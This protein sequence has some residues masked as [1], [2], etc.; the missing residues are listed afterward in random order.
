MN[1]KSLLFTVIAI[2]IATLSGC[3]SVPTNQNYI[4][5]TRPVAI[6]ASVIKVT[7]LKVVAGKDETEILAKSDDDVFSF[8]QRATSITPHE[9]ANV[10]IYH[11][12]K[13]S[14]VIS[15]MNI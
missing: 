1:I 4:G 9:G 12:K 6:E 13:E 10:W 14:R 15:E 3:S 11:S 2:A 8:K 5:A 7:V